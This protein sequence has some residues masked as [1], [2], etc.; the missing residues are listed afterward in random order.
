LASKEANT[1]RTLLY[2]PVSTISQRVI[3]FGILWM[4]SICVALFLLACASAQQH[5]QNTPKGII[6]GVVIGQDGEPAKSLFLQAEPLDPAIITGLP[7][8]KTNEAGEYRFDKLLFG[9]YTIYAEDEHAGYSR[10]STGPSGDSHPPA[11]EIAAENPKAEFNL[12]LPPKAGFIEIHLTNRTNGAAISGMFIRVSS[13]ENPDSL[14]F[15]T[16][17][18]SNHVILVPPDENLLL[19]VESTGFRE[20]DDSVGTGKPVNVPSGEH[21]VLNVQLE[22]S[23]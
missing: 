12:S 2:R 1:R 3:G 21:R 11:V 23:N 7:N 6:Y 17:C 10:I 13:M 14:L 18:N 4:K 9:R 5:Q 16:S 8:T 15:T 20:W 19:H 22:P